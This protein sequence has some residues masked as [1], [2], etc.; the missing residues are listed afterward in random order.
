MAPSAW[1]KGGEGVTIRWALVGTTLGQML[2]AATEQGVCRLSFAEGPE[3]LARRFP[4]AMLVQGGAD[5]AELVQQVVLAVEQPDGGHAIPL[6][7]VGTVFQQ[8]VWDELRRIPS[9]ETRSYGQLA[10]L[11][12]APGASRAVGGANGANPVAVLVPCHRVVAADGTLGGY[13]Y[14]TD[15]KRELL[16]RE[17]GTPAD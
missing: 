11:L 6:D 9:G 4:R 10:A 2:V 3:D 12:G 15:I 8:R 17:R 5:F 14:G 16:R 13:A 1:R 7:V